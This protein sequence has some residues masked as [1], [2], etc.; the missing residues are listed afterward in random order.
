MIKLL[1]LCL[2]VGLMACEDAEP[3][4]DTL[5]A[6]DD[7]EGR[8]SVV[9]EAGPAAVQAAFDEDA[10]LVVTFTGYSGS[11]YQ[12]TDEMLSRVRNVLSGFDPG[13]TV[14]NIGATSDGIGAAYEIASAMGFETTGIVSSQARDAGTAFSPF[15]DRIY[16][17]PDEQWGG[18]VEETGRLSPTS[19]AM[20][21]VSDVLVGIGGGAVTRDELL[22]ARERGKEV[23]FF[24]AELDHQRAFDR[25]SSRG[26]P[27]P[28]DFQG[29][30]H[31]VFGNASGG[32]GR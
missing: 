14:V 2:A 32:P 27:A 15:A 8:S 4:Q 29:E 24:A 31:R 25:A 10:R 11:G 17:V 23:R 1:T 5:Q 13:S 16:I 7:E 26:E 18:I 3:A 21:A 9:V 12:Q 19:E 20:V 30:A 22:A 28:T 6:P